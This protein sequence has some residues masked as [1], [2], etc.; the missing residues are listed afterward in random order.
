MFF[1]TNSN[2]AVITM[3][4]CGHTNMYHY[5]GMEPY[6][7]DYSDKEVVW[8]TWKHHHNPIIVL[9]NP[10]DRVVSAAIHTTN[11]NGIGV[12]NH[13][14]FFVYHSYLYMHQL[15]ECGDFRVIDFYN[16]E[17]YIPRRTD[18]LQSFTTE[19]HVDENIALEDV[20][21]QNSLYTLQAL[22]QEVRDY[23]ELMATRA[24]VSVEEWKELTAHGN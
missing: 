17:Q 3:P 15:V 9:R 18:A 22:R 23:K 12:G 6:S 14:D 2:L 20:Y 16:L 10:I 13:Q 4:R 7:N 5:F 1:Y 8:N 19:T 11:Y 24:Q 21:V